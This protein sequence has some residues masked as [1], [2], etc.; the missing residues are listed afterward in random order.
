[1]H[2][3]KIDKALQ[4]IAEEAALEQHEITEV[5]EKKSSISS[6]SNMNQQADIISKEEQHKSTEVADK[7]NSTSSLSSKRQYADMISEGKQKD[8]NDEW[9]DVNK[10]NWF[11]FA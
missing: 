6:S 3:T 5:A 11:F 2:D 8:S 10:V 9:L 4:R 1:M 7:E